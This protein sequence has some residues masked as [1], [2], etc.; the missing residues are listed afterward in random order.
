MVFTLDR[1][2]PGP[3]ECDQNGNVGSENGQVQYVRKFK[4][5][6]GAIL[7]QAGRFKVFRHDESGATE[8]VVAKGD[9]A[10]IR[11]TVH[12]A[13]KKPT[14]FTFSEL[15]GDLE[16]GDSNSYQNRHVALSNSDVTEPDK[17]RKLTID[18]GPRSVA[19]PGDRA[20]R[21]FC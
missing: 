9:V 21:V 16:F 10:G 4:N 17:R 12:L 6:A 2:G 15:Y 20:G 8:V 3:I 18:P 7:R 5:A 1:N 11:W 14:W 19:K 13:N